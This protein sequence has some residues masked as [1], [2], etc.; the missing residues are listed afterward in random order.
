MD[1]ILFRPAVTLEPLLK[2]YIETKEEEFFRLTHT[3]DKTTKL[4]RERELALHMTLLANYVQQDPAVTA[5]QY[6]LAIKRVHAKKAET[7][8]RPAKYKLSRRN[9]TYSRAVRLW[10][11]NEIIAKGLGTTFEEPM[12][13]EPVMDIE[14][15]SATL[16]FAETI[17]S[18]L[19]FEEFT[20]YTLPRQAYVVFTRE[21][22]VILRMLPDIQN[23]IRHTEWEEHG[24]R[25][26]K[27]EEYA[28][29]RQQPDIQLKMQEFLL[30]SMPPLSTEDQAPSAK[31]QVAA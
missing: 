12:P 14:E 24:K 30:R 23:L 22:R 6:E 11:L 26:L 28:I 17:S 31:R 3:T 27:F 20:G 1:P 5:T 9:V 29:L 13:P 4:L 18:L 7:R 8:G 25:C 2:Q 15:Q 16:G 21:D 19:R 10:F